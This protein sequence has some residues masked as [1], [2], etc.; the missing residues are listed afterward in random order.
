MPRPSALSTSALAVAV[1]LAGATARAQEP[2]K[3]PAKPVKRLT[4]SLDTVLP[5]L[6]AAV[7]RV[8][9]PS[10]GQVAAGDT[11]LEA[12]RDGVATTHLTGIRVGNDLVI[13]SIPDIDP[14]P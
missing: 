2:A 9:T 3:D 4:M 11:T 6:N 13:V 14:P 8:R 12:A 10:E 1:A 5:L 7:V